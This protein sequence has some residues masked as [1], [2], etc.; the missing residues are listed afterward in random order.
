MPL[1]FD[2]A[3]PEFGLKS[4]QALVHEG[5]EGQEKAM[6]T[7]IETQTPIKIDIFIDYT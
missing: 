7:T 4:E 5:A 2:V 3:Y 1:R 6:P